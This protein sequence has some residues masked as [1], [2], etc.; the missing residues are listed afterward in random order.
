MTRLAL[1]LSLALAQSPAP[2]PDELL[3][4]AKL[5]LFDRDW[6]AARAHCERLLMTFPKS[7]RAPQAR[8][9]LA[10]AHEGA[11]QDRQALSAYQSFLRLYPDA[12]ELRED[13]RTA[14]IGLA[15]KLLDRGEEECWPLLK[16]GL[17][18]RSPAVR[19]YTALQVSALANRRRARQAV[20]V[21]AEVVRSE[22]IPD[23]QDRARIALLRL[24]P[25]ALVRAEESIR[26]EPEQG[27]R[28]HSVRGR[29]LKLRIYRGRSGEQE[30]RLVVPLAL[31]ELV[32]RALAED[33]KRELRREKGIDLDNFWTELE[34]LGPGKILGIETE[35]ERFELWIE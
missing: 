34:K 15:R 1:A 30:V 3:R 33:L 19:A 22:S 16:E 6:A 5:A 21:L 18:D 12:H 7:P 25:R 14:A 4:E 31:G 28:R 11:G 35:R 13:A 32:Y 8:F 24:D 27:L 20:P 2:S 23:V 17:L 26:L 29:W 9:F 10:R